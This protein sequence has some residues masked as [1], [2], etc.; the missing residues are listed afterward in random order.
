MMLGTR[1]KKEV[2]IRIISQKGKRKY[3]LK[4]G[5][6]GIVGGLFSEEFVWVHGIIST[7][8]CDFYATAG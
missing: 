3:N 6:E 7:P 2:R 8:T 5:D 1:G 4:V